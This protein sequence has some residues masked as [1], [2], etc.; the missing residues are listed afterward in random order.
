MIEGVALIKGKY[1]LL[2]NHPYD[3]WFSSSPGPDYRAANLMLSSAC[4]AQSMHRN[5]YRKRKQYCKI[6]LIIEKEID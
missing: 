4:K 2:L 3:A 1:K 6:E 5:T